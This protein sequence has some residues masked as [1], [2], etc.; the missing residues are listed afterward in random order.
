M[1]EDFWN[2][3]S[4]RVDIVPSKSVELAQECKRQSENCLYTSTSFHIWLRFLRILKVLFVIVPLIL[5][6][7]AGWKLLTTSDLQAV[8]LLTACSAF[9]AG[10][11]PTI[12]AAL[13]FDEN[14]EQCRSLAGEFKNLQDRFRQAALISSKKTFAEF[15]QDVKPV[16]ERLEKA[17]SASFTAPEWCFRRA[18]KKIKSGDY[19]FDVDINS[20]ERSEQS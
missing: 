15:E 11:L 1:A 10:L 8:K 13:K 16:L 4:C 17:R 14:L 2:V 6:S 20:I 5:G 7:L 19:E 18:Q 9:L 12:Y 3:Y